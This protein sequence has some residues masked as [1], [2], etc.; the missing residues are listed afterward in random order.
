VNCAYD[1][2]RRKGVNVES[3]ELDEEKLTAAETP[4]RDL[5]AEEILRQALACLSV[6]HREV[7]VLHVL[8]ENSV[9]EVA[10]ILGI[11]PGT[12]KSRLF[13][14]MRSSKPKNHRN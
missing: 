9:E 2:F 1:H 3:E 8:E 13:Q 5:G 7:L 10:Q 11:A 4:P 12:V 14:V 6:P